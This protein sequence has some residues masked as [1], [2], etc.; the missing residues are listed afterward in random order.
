MVKATVLKGGIDEKTVTWEI[1]TGIKRAAAN[2]IVTYHANE[3]KSWLNQ[4]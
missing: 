1:T 2:L 3:A 4:L